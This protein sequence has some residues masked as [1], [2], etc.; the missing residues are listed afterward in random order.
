MTQEELHA[1]FD[2]AM[3][4]GGDK[5]SEAND[6]VSELRGVCRQVDEWA[7]RA[8]DGPGQQPVADAVRA[9]KEA[10]TAIEKELV[11]PRA[12]GAL[13][14]LNYPVKLVIKLGALTSVV[15]NADAPPTKQA[16]E[17]YDL[18]AGQIDVQLTRLKETLDS[19]VPAFAD[20]LREHQVPAVVPGSEPVSAMKK[21]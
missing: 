14:R 10:L 19:R 17:V 11:E 20:L 7:G 3:R 13:N 2:L 21:D 1:Q 5:L 9:L 8:K 15:T 12:D 6:A 4:I 18:L 16:Y